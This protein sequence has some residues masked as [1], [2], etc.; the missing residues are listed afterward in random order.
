MPREQWFAEA[1]ARVAA[2]FLRRF[3]ADLHD[4][5]RQV[6]SHHDDTG[7]TMHRLR[8]WLTH[9]QGEQHERLVLLCTVTNP[10][11]TYSRLRMSYDKVRPWHK[12]A[13]QGVSL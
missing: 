11:R 5:L 7:E 3:L 13:S 8:I 6:H 10:A 12:P 2:A 9:L 1:C 4:D